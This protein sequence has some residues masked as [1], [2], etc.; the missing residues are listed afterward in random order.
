MSGEATGLPDLSSEAVTAYLDKLID[1]DL[2]AAIAD[3][4]GQTEAEI[5]TTLRIYA[6]EAPVGVGLLRGHDLTG[7]RV[8]EVGAGIGLQTCYLLNAG[9]NIESVE[10]E[11]VGFDNNHLLIEHISRKAALQ[12]I[13]IHAIGAE[14][15]DPAVHG[16]FDVIF[17]LNVLEHIAELE[18]AIAA[19]ARVL[20]PGGIMIHDCPNYVAPYEPHYG[21][22]LMPFAPQNTFWAG[23]RRAE[24]VWRS[25]NFITANRL[26]RTAAANGL[27]VDFNRGLMAAAFDR[28][29]TDDVFATRHSHL[30]MAAQAMSATGLLWLL[31]QAPPQWTTPMRVTMRA[32]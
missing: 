16:K 24:P 14:A 3:A 27:K 11:G 22:P 18:D 9:V 8:L 31:R 29:L 20:A 26:V 5:A 12:P 21:I 2:I 17:S 7:K 25:L 1:Q 30:K 6:S 32:A 28:I 4:T 19:M 13:P 10:P 15:L 23:A